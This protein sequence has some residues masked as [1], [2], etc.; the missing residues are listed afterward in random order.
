M[1]LPTLATVMMAVLANPYAPWWSSDGGEGEDGGDG[2]S[3]VEP[4]KKLRRVGS[5]ASS[6]AGD[7]AWPSL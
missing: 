7:P 6:S 3:L 5:D 1:S 4:E 2:G